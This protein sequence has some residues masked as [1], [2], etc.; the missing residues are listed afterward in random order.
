METHRHVQAHSSTFMGAHAM[1]KA[2]NWLEM[3]ITC[4]RREWR[5]INK[6]RLDIFCYLTQSNINKYRSI[7]LQFLQRV[8]QPERSEVLKIN[9]CL[10]I[11]NTWLYMI[12]CLDS[13]WVWQL[14]LLYGE[15]TAQLKTRGNSKIRFHYNVCLQRYK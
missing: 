11:R 4:F 14:N 15:Q 9:T 6:P 12:S 5:T 1:M 7:Q 3:F 2:A 10:P 8:T 13:Y